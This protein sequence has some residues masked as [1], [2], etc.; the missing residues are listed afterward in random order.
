MNRSAA[1]WAWLLHVQCICRPLSFFSHFLMLQPHATQRFFEMLLKKE[2]RKKKQK[3]HIDISSQT[4]SHVLILVIIFEMSLHFDWSP[5]VFSTQPRLVD[6]CSDG[7][8]FWRFGSR[9]QFLHGSVFAWICITSCRTL[10]TLGVCL[11][12]SHHMDCVDS[13]PG[14]E[15]SQRWSNEMG[16][17][18]ASLLLARKIVSY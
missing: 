5:S 3:C 10:Y 11:S 2:K 7:L 6:C 9:S 8:F 17:T 4:H 1:A 15:V 18:W 16:G 13:G 14:V 12:K